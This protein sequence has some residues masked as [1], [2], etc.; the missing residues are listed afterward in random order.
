VSRRTNILL[1]VAL[2]TGVLYGY[3]GVPFFLPLVSDELPMA[4]EPECPTLSEVEDIRL[5]M[6]LLKRGMKHSDAEE[7]LGLASGTGTIGMGGTPHQTPMLRVP[8]R[9]Q[10]E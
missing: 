5:R 4:E 1:M 2:A 10:R 8:G 9:V 7:V 6:L 3:F